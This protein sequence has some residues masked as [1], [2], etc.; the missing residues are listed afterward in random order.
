VRPNREALGL[1]HLLDPTGSQHEGVRAVVAWAQLAKL[2]PI[3]GARVNEKLVHEPLEV[4][5]VDQLYRSAPKVSL[6]RV[7]VGAQ[8][9]DRAERY[10]GPYARGAD[11]AALEAL[12][13][14]HPLLPRAQILVAFG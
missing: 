7:S 13:E 12:L 14:R 10:V 2:Y 11:R 4:L 8:A 9:D 5:G 6:H 1:D 3:L